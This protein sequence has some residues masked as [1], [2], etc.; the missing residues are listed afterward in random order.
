MN[1]SDASSKKQ[2]TINDSETSSSFHPLRNSTPRSQ[3]VD[4]NKSKG[5]FSTKHQNDGHEHLVNKG[6]PSE[7]A[8]KSSS[9]PSSAEQSQAEKKSVSGSDLSEDELI[10]SFSSLPHTLPDE[11]DMFGP[12]LRRLESI[13]WEDSSRSVASVLG[14]MLTNVNDLSSDLEMRFDDDAPDSALQ[15]SLKNDIQEELAEINELFSTYAQR[16]P[17]I[18]N[19]EATAEAL[20]EQLEALGYETGHRRSPSQMHNSYEHES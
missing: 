8:L 10:G 5:S 15:M 11:N 3:A 2:T 14:E 9:E 7:G 4:G 16:H 1:P 20:Y 13:H 18:C 12:H 6:T 19:D 17:S